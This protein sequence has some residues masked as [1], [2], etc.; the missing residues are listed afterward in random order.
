MAVS[1]VGLADLATGRLVVVENALC[2]RLCGLAQNAR[3]LV[4][5]DFRQEL[6]ALAKGAELS[7]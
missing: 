5:A 2:R 6:E 3:G 1:V 7:Q 4:S